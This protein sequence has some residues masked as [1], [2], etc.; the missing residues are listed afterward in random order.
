M[1]DQSV[2]NSTIIDKNFLPHINSGEKSQ[3]IRYPIDREMNTGIP[4]KASKVLNQEVF[5]ECHNV[6][7]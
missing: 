4:A 6:V 7:P 2:L 3:L 1:I 5:S